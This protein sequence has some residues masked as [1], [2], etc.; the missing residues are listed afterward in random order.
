MRYFGENLGGVK[1]F[2]QK[3]I[4]CLKLYF[5]KMGEGKI[6]ECEK[7]S[8]TDKYRVLPYLHTLHFHLYSDILDGHLTLIFQYDSLP[9]YSIA[10]S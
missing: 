9:K 8:K 7:C 10:N 1:A 6:F 2:F 5:G 4:G 3:K